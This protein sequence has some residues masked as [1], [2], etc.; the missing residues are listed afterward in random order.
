MSRS[1]SRAAAIAQQLGVK[2]LRGLELIAF[3]DNFDLGRAKDTRYPR[4]ATAQKARSR[5]SQI[6]HEKI[7]AERRLLKG[8]RQQSMPQPVKAD[9]P[10][11]APDQL[12]TCFG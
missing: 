2:E 12:C 3:I 1:E 9:G 5:A 11:V 7:P 6:T 10:C 8:A 4:E